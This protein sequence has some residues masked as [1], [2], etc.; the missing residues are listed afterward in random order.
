MF[1]VL[2]LIIHDKLQVK[3]VL[4]SSVSWNLCEVRRVRHHHPHQRA[5]RSGR[6]WETGQSLRELSV[7]CARRIMSS[8]RR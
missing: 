4:S 3:S 8:G 1:V 5:V 2:I 6:E 7:C